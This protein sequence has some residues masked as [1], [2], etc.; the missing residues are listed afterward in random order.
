MDFAV[1]SPDTI[2]TYDSDTS[3]EER[4]V[5]ILLAGEHI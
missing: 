4:Y 2:R 5:I 3:S 1:E